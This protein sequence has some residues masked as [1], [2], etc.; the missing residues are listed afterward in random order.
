MDDEERI[1][2]RCNR[3]YVVLQQRNQTVGKIL[4]K[5]FGC[6]MYFLLLCAIG[7]IA[8]GIILNMQ[9]FNDDFLSGFAYYFFIGGIGVVLLLIAYVAALRPDKNLLECETCGFKWDRRREPFEQQSDHSQQ[10]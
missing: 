6:S 9:I 4:R 3:H 8:T 1:C 2:P 7:F 5:D 10:S